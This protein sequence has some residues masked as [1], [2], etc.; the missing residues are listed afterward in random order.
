[1]TNAQKRKLDRATKTLTAYYETALGTPSIKY[2]L[3]WALRKTWLDFSIEEREIKPKKWDI[4]YY[5]TDCTLKGTDAC[6]YD[7]RGVNDEACQ[8]YTTEAYIER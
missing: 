5:C 4:A 2:P 7:C 6:P 3:S 8:S 1:M